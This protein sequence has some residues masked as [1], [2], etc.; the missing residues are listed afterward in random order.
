MVHHL[1]TNVP[2]QYYFRAVDGTI[3]KNLSDLGAALLRMDENTFKHHA[4]PQ[5]NDFHNWVRDMYKDQ[6]LALELL[7]AKSRQDA[8][9]AVSRRIQEIS[10]PFTPVVPAVVRREILP[11]PKPTPLQVQ[12]I[13]ALKVMT[14]LKSPPRNPS[15]KPPSS[16]KKTSLKTTSAPTIVSV[17]RN[18]TPVERDS[19]PRKTSISISLG[20]SPL[21][22]HQLMIT[23]IAIIFIIFFL[24]TSAQ[25]LNLTGAVTAGPSPEEVQFVG[26]WGVV[27]V[28]V[29]VI[30][31]LKVVRERHGRK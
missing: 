27:A 15:K 26:I 21:Q 14:P 16:R 23:A 30:I 25:V 3:I 12:V 19:T 31:A 17:S 24:G 22:K 18:V 13:P 11:L 9:I 29:L 10:K 20:T 8:A 6:R 4:N 7:H 1:L 5:R 2:E 28:V